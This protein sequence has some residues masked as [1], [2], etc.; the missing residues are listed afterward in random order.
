MAVSAIDGTKR[1]ICVVQPPVPKV[2]GIGEV[3]SSYALVASTDAKSGR[4]TVDVY[5]T[6]NK[7]V[8][9]HLLLSPGHRAVGV[10]GLVTPT[11]TNDGNSPVR[12]SS[13]I[14]LTSGGSIVTLTE[15]G[16]PEKVS[17]LVQKSLY[18]AA[19]SMAY[20]DP[21]FEPAEI[22]GLYRRHAEHL[23]RMGDYG[24]AMEQYIHTIGSLESSHVIFRYLDA[25]KIP[26]L[27]KYLEEL[28]TRDMATSVHNELLRTC[29][30]K[31]N[32][33]DAA[34][35]IAT[36]TATSA[37]DKTSLSS[38]VSTLAQNPK[39]A[40]AIICSYDAPQAAEAIVMHGPALVRVLPRETAGIVVSL[41]LGTYSSQALSDAATA[42]TA[43]V[44]K[45]LEQVS[46][47]R[48]KA[49]EPYPVHLFASAFLENS[50]MLRLILAHCNRNKCP[51]TP[52]L[53]RTLLELTLAEWNQS[54]RSGD[55]E[56]EKLRRKEAIAVSGRLLY[57]DAK[58]QPI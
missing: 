25:P 53:R 1:A 31:L 45:M 40:L 22:T 19:I 47:D 3:G 26:Y 20:A 32:D 41:C 52:P 36:S 16:T 11:R 12:R 29:F 35:K 13:L 34:E 56:S 17:L 37:D 5:D 30:L 10:A 33:P 7:L 42:T 43:E 44:N 14:V 46:D 57:V 39:E 24:A 49:C 27:V 23:Y 6:T 50:K 21:S 15:K 2:L 8:A 48:N 9:F 18:S 54:K 28:K 4:D 51:L 55:T 38:L 58:Q